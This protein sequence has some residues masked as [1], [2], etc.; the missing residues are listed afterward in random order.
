MFG[1]LTDEEIEVFLNAA[2]YALGDTISFDEIATH[3]DIDD[4]ELMKMKEKLDEYLRS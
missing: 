2:G 1:K 4:D 3:L